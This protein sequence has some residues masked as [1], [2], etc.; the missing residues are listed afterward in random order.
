[1]ERTEHRLERTTFRTPRELDFFAE[2]KLVSQTGFERQLWDL[3][4]VKELID[5]ALDAAEEADGVAPAVEV[6]ADPAGTTPVHEADQQL[7]A[8]QTN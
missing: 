7:G 1:M 8:D 5:N 4:I 3:V 2:N 6:A